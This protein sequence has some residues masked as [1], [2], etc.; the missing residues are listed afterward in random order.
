MS[1][2]IRYSRISNPNPFCIVLF[3]IRILLLIP[4]FFSF[5]TFKIDLNRRIKTYNQHAEYLV[6]YT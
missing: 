1:L 6:S 2:L 4:E 5:Q 3:F